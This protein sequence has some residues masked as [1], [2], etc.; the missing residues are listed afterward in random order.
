VTKLKILRCG[1]CG[2]FCDSYGNE[3]EAT[4]QLKA[5]DKYVGFDD[6][7]GECKKCRTI[8]ID[9][10]IEHNEIDEMLAKQKDKFYRSRGG[11]C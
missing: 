5:A 2:V 7:L 1:F 6:A 3:F 4:E 10:I 11:Q 8:G 9:E